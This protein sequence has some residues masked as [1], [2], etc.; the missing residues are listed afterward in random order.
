MAD[1]LDKHKKKPSEVIPQNGTMTMEQ[2]NRLRRGEPV[3][4]IPEVPK[5]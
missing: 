4:R 1:A 3:H 2:Y 5:W